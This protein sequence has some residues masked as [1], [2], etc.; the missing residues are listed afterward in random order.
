M[1]E[2]NIMATIYIA[3][4]TLAGLGFFFVYWSTLKREL[5]GIEKF[6]NI[7]NRDLFIKGMGEFL[8]AK[9]SK[10]P[11][12]ISNPPQTILELYGYY[13]KWMQRLNWKPWLVTAVAISMQLFLGLFTIVYFSEGLK[14][15][16]ALVFLASCT[17]LVILVAPLF[18][19]QANKKK[20][21]LEEIDERF[22]AMT[23]PDRRAFAHRDFEGQY[24]L[25]SRLNAIYSI[26]TLTTN[27][28]ISAHPRSI[29]EASFLIRGCLA[30]LLGLAFLIFMV[31]LGG[32]L[33]ACFHLSESSFSIFPLAGL[34]GIPVIWF[35]ALVFWE[36]RK[37]RRAGIGRNNAQTP[38]AQGAYSLMY[39][40]PPLHVLQG[41]QPP[42]SVPLEEKRICPKCGGSVARYADA[43]P[44]CGCQLLE[45]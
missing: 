24:R 15:R 39:A 44:Y 18:I 2:D 11:I 29:G 20:E 33:T 31:I 35:A 3:L 1:N 34:I 10:N 5:K 12:Y 23:A 9:L 42:D 21:I 25:A 7:R 22:L 14:I 43:C 45:A 36:A 32:V 30:F 16:S 41:F 4:I 26:P 6:I 13:R 8:A 17:T 27:E 19:K 28:D 40:Y 38:G 37:Q